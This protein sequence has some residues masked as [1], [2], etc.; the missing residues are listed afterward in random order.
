MILAARIGQIIPSG[1]DRLKNRAAIHK[2]ADLHYL[3]YLPWHD[4]YLELVD[5][6]CRDF[7]KIV[8]PHLHARSPL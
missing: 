2:S 7:F 6:A 5:G 1:M 3:I 8:L 4:K